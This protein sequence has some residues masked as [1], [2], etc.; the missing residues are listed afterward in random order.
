MLIDKVIWQEGMLLRPQHLQHNDRYYHQQLTRRSQLSQGYAW[1]F[2]T[3]EIDP[4]Y[5]DMGKVVVNQA[6]GVL[7]DGILFDMASPLVMQI[8]ANSPGQAV[9]LALPMLTGNAAEVRDPSQTDVLARY[10]TYEVE[11]ADANAGED[12]RCAISCARADFRLLLGDD[13]EVQTYVRLKVAQVL[14]CNAQGVV[15][16]DSTFSPTFMHLQLALFVVLPQG[17]GQPIGISR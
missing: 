11:V 5:L 17:G 7:P 13:H 10:T 2:L 15:Q 6:S 16:L 9:Y 3:L 1:G 12:T 8:P 14:D 4:Q